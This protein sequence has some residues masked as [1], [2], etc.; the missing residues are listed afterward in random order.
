[1]HPANAGRQSLK[2]NP[3][4]RHVEPLVQMRIIRNQFFDLRVGLVNI[5]RV[6]RERGPAEWSDAAAEQR[7]DVLRH[8]TRDIERTSDAGIMGDL[9]QI[10]AVVE[11]RQAHR[12]EAQQIL[13]VL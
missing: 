11:Y 3:R 12:L 13:D 1:A 2:L 8:E 4:T 10:V 5:F 6:S 7:P 9:P